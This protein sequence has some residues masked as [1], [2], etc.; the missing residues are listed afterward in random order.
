MS[1]WAACGDPIVRARTCLA[2]ALLILMAGNVL[3]HSKTDVI[4]LENGSSI[5]GEI[6]GLLEGSLS[7]GTD[8]MGTV[9]VQWEDVV[10]VTSEFKY[11]V[12]LQNGERLYGSLQAAPDPRNVRVVE[13]DGQ[14]A[15]AI[16]DV[17][18]LRPLEERRADRFDA[19]IGLG[20]SNDNASGVSTFSLTT[21]V[22]YQ[23]ERG[24]TDLNGRTS[25]TDLEDGTV[26]SNRY[27]ISRQFWTRRPQVVRW[28]DGSY[29][30]NDE[31]NLDYR[32]TAGFGFGRAMYDTNKLSLIAILGL[33]GAH[34]K[35]EFGETLTSVE[36]VLGATFSIWRFDTPE[37]D[38]STDLTLYPGITEG[39]RWRGNADIRLSW[40]LVADFY[41]DLTT[42]A[43]YD[44]QS[45]SGSDTDYGITMG[46]AWDY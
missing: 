30:D 7:F 37:L 11:E 33:Q 41:W 36:G 2:A 38:L 4:V 16:L 17:V 23:D 35:I 28:F 10:E 14:S 5:K 43:T 8:S 27:S 24:V 31:L 9:K 6:K 19:R 18:E 26:R 20:Y 25:R 29:E 46:L 21:A 42:W 15:I 44:N 3:A 34:E 32:Y 40:E 1:A 22:G 13:A 39:G 45:Q 12:R